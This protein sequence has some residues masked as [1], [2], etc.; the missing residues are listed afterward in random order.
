MV[1]PIFA[2]LAHYRCLQAADL[3]AYTARR[4]AT[5]IRRKLSKADKYFQIEGVWNIIW[6]EI[7]RKGPQGDVLGYD[8]KVCRNLLFALTVFVC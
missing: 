3:I 2:N 4:V 1:D 7:L 8:Y 6:G 5:K